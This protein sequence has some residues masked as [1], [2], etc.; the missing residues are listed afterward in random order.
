MF[1]L[2]ILNVLELIHI[3]LIALDTV[4]LLVLKI[5]DGG[6]TETLREPEFK[7][8]GV[9]TFVMTLFSTAFS[10][11]IVRRPMY[12]VFIL[13]PVMCWPHLVMTG[14]F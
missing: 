2:V 7:L 11:D 10:Q 6:L 5:P 8:Q 4:R 1:C 9:T 12:Y 14:K 13:L 3:F